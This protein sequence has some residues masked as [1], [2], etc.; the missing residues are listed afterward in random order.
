MRVSPARTTVEELI[1]QKE[2]S[3]CKNTYSCHLHSPASTP[4]PPHPCSRGTG[5]TSEACR[6]HFKIICWANE[7]RCSLLQPRQGGFW[8]AVPPLSLLGSS[9]L[10]HAFWRAAVSLLSKVPSESLADL[11]SETLT[12]GTSLCQHPEP[13][14]QALPTHLASRNGLLLMQTQ[15]M[16]MPSTKPLTLLFQKDPN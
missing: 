11:R 2:H 4:S 8:I 1:K 14:Q 5:I 13:L 15:R 3:L 12:Q 10:Y 16:G 6:D 7:V 9:A